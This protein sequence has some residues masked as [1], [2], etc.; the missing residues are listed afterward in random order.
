MKRYINTFIISMISISV[1][2]LIGCERHTEAWQKLDIAEGL[3]ESRPDSSLVILNSITEENLGGKAE[4]ARY[5]LLKSMALDKNYIDTTDFKVLQP[6]IDYYMKKGSANEKL[7]TYY[8]QGRIYQNRGDL[9]SAMYSFVNA[10][11]NI[12]PDPDS[13]CLAR[14]LVAQ[15]GINKDFYNLDGYTSCYLKASEIYALLDKEENEFDCLN[16]VLN[17]A[18]MLGHKE[19]ADSVLK[20]CIKYE[21]SDEMYKPIIRNYLLTYVLRFGTISDLKGY[22]ST[23]DESEQVNPYGILNLA[24]TYSKLGENQ[25]AKYF[26]DYLNENQWDYDTLK[27][28]I[29]SSNV[30][31]GLGDVS[32][33][34]SAYKDYSNRLDALNSFKFERSVHYIEDKHNMELQAQEEERQK[35]MILMWW[36][37]SAVLLLLI[38]VILLL[39]VRSNKAKKELA[40]Q[41]ATTAELENEKLQSEKDLAEQR[42]MTIQIDNDRLKSERKNLE[43]TNKNLKLE[44]D[45]K[46]LEA[47]NLAHRVEILENE[48]ESL[49]NLL[50]EQEEL[51]RQEELPLEVRNAI[52][53]RI[54]MLNSLLAGHITENNEFEKTYTNWVEEHT[55]NTA[56]FMNTNR[57]AFQASHPRFIQ[58]FEDH[59]LTVDEINYVCLY[60]I[61]LRGKE[62]GNYI[63]RRSHV[64]VSSAI[65]KKL[66]IDK[67]ETNIGIYVRKLLKQL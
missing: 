63:K 54:E 49:K 62:V 61:G 20:I 59:N 55:E 51:P 9:D 35:S 67:H 33:A 50:H 4:S 48:S 30:L 56:E 39:S 38:V 7:R 6:A 3:M 15:G 18:I 5:A 34:L 1:L 45:N 19:L 60:A 21:S 26:L 8:Y 44:R 14:T 17:G 25:K 43:L 47:E 27:F 46:I 66:G 52:K 64:N 37:V 36:I 10:F 57:L 41:R 32:G 31:E 23:N 42:A 29:I 65:R 40:N 12:G 22:I 13:L 28:S 16:N 11:D 24:L 58:Y 2:T 53:V